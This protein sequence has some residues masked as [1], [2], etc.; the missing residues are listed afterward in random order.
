MMASPCGGACR[1]QPVTTR[2]ATTSLDGSLCTEGVVQC[3][4]HV[5]AGHV[6]CF[7][8]VFKFPQRKCISTT[9]TYSASSGSQAPRHAVPTQAT[10]PPPRGRLT[11]AVWSRVRRATSCRSL[12]LLPLGTPPCVVQ[13]RPEMSSLVLPNRAPLSPPGPPVPARP[14]R[15][16]LRGG[17]AALQRDSAGGGPGSEGDFGVIWE[18]RW[19]PPPLGPQPH[20]RAGRLA[21]TVGQVP[22][23]L[24]PWAGVL[25]VPAAPAPAG[26]APPPPA[27]VGAAPGTPWKRR[28]WRRRAS[29]RSRDWDVPARSERGPLRRV[30][31]GLG[32]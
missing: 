23:F 28:S 24:L 6:I 29:S 19:P 4:W 32:R 7:T 13:G 31:E 18:T 2:E 22:G 12:I 10:P 1:G 14:P 27:P 25:G 26:P 8:S 20:R 16:G 17:L 5:C 21:V 30:G 9:C 11:P 15:R 3:V